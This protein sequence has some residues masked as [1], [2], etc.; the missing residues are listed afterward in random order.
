[1]LCATILLATLCSCEVYSQGHLLSLSPLVSFDSFH[2]LGLSPGVD[3]GA[4]AGIRLMPTVTFMTTLSFGT[5]NEPFDLIGASDHFNVR[6]IVYEATLEQF[7]LG[8][9]DGAAVAILLGGGGLSSTIDARSVSL[10]ALGSMTVPPRSDTEG[11]LVTG[12]RG[13]F[14]LTSGA[15]VTIAPRLRV[16][17]PFASST[18]DLSITGGIRVGLF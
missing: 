17:R 18:T 16:F 15:A 2:S 1:L 4:A 14:P 6:I 12:L 9:P 3:F 10:G 11:F 8:E 7:L 13:I 5:R